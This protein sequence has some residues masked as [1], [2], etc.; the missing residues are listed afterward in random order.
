MV[1]S[2]RLAVSVS[3]PDIFLTVLYKNSRPLYSKLFILTFILFHVSENLGFP[4]GDFGELFL[5]NTGRP[6]S[7]HQSLFIPKSGTLRT[8]RY[9][10]FLT[11]F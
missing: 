9:E 2:K 10:M 4:I 1:G 11:C 7:H 6:V 8:E 3:S 5:D